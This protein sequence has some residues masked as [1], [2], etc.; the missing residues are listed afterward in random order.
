MAWSTLKTQ[1]THL[2]NRPLEQGNIAQFIQHTL[3]REFREFSPKF[4]G[5][6]CWKT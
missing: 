1:P 4:E 6:K 2:S 3:Y 5:A